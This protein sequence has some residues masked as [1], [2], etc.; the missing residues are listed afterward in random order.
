MLKIFSIGSVPSNFVCQTQ[1]NKQILF[2]QL[3][4]YEIFK[5]TRQ[6]PSHS[7]SKMSFRHRHLI[8]QTADWFE[9]HRL[10]MYSEKWCQVPTHNKEIGRRGRICPGQYNFSVQSTWCLWVGKQH[11]FWLWTVGEV[12]WLCR[13]EG[14][15]NKQSTYLDVYG[16]R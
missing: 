16:S 13:Q 1:Y 5:I 7:C 9:L 10:S 14:R 2:Q 8:K 11:Q 3:F 4:E 15:A 6:D 12:N